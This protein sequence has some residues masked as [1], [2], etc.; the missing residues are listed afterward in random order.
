[1]PRT[2]D[3]AAHAANWRTLLIVDACLGLVV[4]I[5]GA[6]MA[7]AVNVV[8]G[9]LFVAVGAL[10]VSLVAARARRWNRLRREAGD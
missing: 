8:V 2:D 7:V 6:A 9:T 5:A 10:Y 4:V 1:M 3:S